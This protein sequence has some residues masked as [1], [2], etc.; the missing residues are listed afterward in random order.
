[1]ELIQGHNDEGFFRL[2]QGERLH[3]VGRFED[4]VDARAKELQAS[5]YE[6]E[7]CIHVDG[8]MLVWFNQPESFSGTR[9]ELVDSGQRESM[10]NMIESR[11]A[12]RG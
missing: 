12:F 2:D 9:I 11:P 3:H 6:R 7:A 10:F 5:G 8:K 1:V 4:D